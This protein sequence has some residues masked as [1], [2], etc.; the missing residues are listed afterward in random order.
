MTDKVLFLTHRGERHQQSALAGAPADF[1]I[2]MLHNA[3]KD[4]II[5]NISGKK[6]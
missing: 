6:F 2:T 4:E 1:E 5:K 3:T